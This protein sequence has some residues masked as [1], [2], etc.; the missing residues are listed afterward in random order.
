MLQF[1]YGHWYLNYS[2]FPLWNNG[3]I[4]N[5]S[6]NYTPT[7]AEGILYLLDEVN[8]LE[9]GE[10]KSIKGVDFE[11]S[12]NP[13]KF[14]WRGAGWLFWLKSPWQIEWVNE[15]NTCLVL[16]FKKTL[17]SSGGIDIICK[18][19]FPRQDT[20]NAALS[21]INENKT[22]QKKA[23]NLFRVLQQ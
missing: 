12:E 20:L 1:L 16:S 23:R 8:Y 22:L 15:A 4:T 6:F 9:D 2:N 17:F 19:R 11:Q 18:E 13:F 5:V 14:I 10:S 3:K 21:A 7:Q